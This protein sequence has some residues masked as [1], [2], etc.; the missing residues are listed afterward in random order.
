MNEDFRLRVVTVALQARSD[1]PRQRKRLNDAINECVRLSGFRSPARAAEPLLAP[2]VARRCLV[3]PE[4]VTAILDIWFAKES[5]LRAQVIEFLIKSDMKPVNTSELSPLAFHYWNLEEMGEA[6]DAFAAAN[7]GIDK[8][9][10]CLMICCVLDAVPLPI[11]IVQMIEQRMLEDAPEADGDNSSEEMTADL[12]SEPLPEPLQKFLRNLEPLMADVAGCDMIVEFARQLNALIERKALELDRMTRV[13]ELQ[14]MLDALVANESMVTYF[15]LT[16]MADWHSE[17]CKAYKLDQLRDLLEDL[18]RRF[19]AFQELQR[20]E[21]PET[22]HEKRAQRDEEDAHEKGILDAVAALRELLV[23]DDVPPTPGQELSLPEPASTPEEAGDNLAEDTER[24]SEAVAET[25]LEKDWG[26]SEIN[27]AAAESETPD[28]SGVNKQVSEE[29][30]GPRPDADEEASDASLKAPGVNYEPVAAPSDSSP[31]AQDVPGDALCFGSQNA[32]HTVA[33]SGPEA[34]DAALGVQGEVGAGLPELAKGSGA[35]A[36]PL[37]TDQSSGGAA[38]RDETPSAS[39]QTLDPIWKAIGRRDIAL[40]YWLA[41]ADEQVGSEAPLSSS[42]LG[43][44]FGAARV[45]PGSG[46]FIADLRSLSQW[47][48]AEDCVAKKVLAAAAVVRIWPVAPDVVPEWPTLAVPQLGTANDLLELV[49]RF[50]E[51]GITP[52]PDELS[53]GFQA[54]DLAREAAKIA[55][56]AEAWVSTARFRRPGLKRAHDVW[57]ALVS[58]QDGRL[59]SLVTLVRSDH[60]ESLELVDDLVKEW[61]QPGYADGVIDDLTAAIARRKDRR[62]VG[63]NRQKL[64]RDVREAVELADTWRG[65]ARQR[66]EQSIPNN[67]RRENLSKF[68]TS[69]REL[70]PQALDDI[71]ELGGSPGLGDETRAALETLREGVLALRRWV[72]TE[73]MATPEASVPAGLD[74]LVRVCR[75]LP[76]ALSRRLLYYPD[77]RLGDDAQPDPS[78]AAGLKTVLVNLSLPN[79]SLDDALKGWVANQDYRF[80]EPLLRA[81]GENASASQLADLCAH[82]LTDSRDALTRATQ[83][84]TSAIEQ[85]TI[86]GVLAD[87]RAEMLADVASIDPTTTLNCWQGH[88]LLGGLKAKLAALRA[89]RLDELREIWQDLQVDCEVLVGPVPSALQLRQ[90]MESAL[91]RGDTRVAEEL[92]DRARLAMEQS[93]PLDE[94]LWAQPTSRDS[95]REYLSAIADLDQILKRTGGL[96]LVWRAAKSGKTMA[97]IQFGGLPGPRRDEIDKGLVA[98]RNLKQGTPRSTGNVDNVRAILEYLGFRPTP[99]Q[100]EASKTTRSSVWQHMTVRAAPTGNPRAVPQFGSQALGRYDVIA[101]W[102]RPGIDTLTTALRELKLANKPVIVLYLGCLSDRQRQDLVRLSRQHM[103]TI[104]L[105]DETLVVY[106]AGQTDS[107]LPAFLRCALPFSAPMPYTP[108]QAGDVPQE[109]FYGREEMARQL[110]EFTGPCLLYGGRQLGK[111]ALLRHVERQFSMPERGQHAWVQDLRVA[112]GGLS[113]GDPEEL[114]VAL[115]DG[116]KAHGLIGAR[117]A[118]RK[119]EEI[120]RYIREALKDMTS[121][122]LVLMDESDGFLEADARQGFTT[123]IALRELILTTERRLKVVFAGLHNVRRFYGMP[124]QPLAHFGL[125]LCVGP[126]EPSAAEALVVEP[127]AAIGYRFKDAASVL[128][129]LSYTN[130]HPGLIQLFGQELLKELYRR[131]TLSYPP[132]LIEDQVVEA[133]YRRPDVRERIRERLDWTLALDTRYQVIAWSLIEDQ[134][135]AHDSYRQAYSPGEILEF[136]RYWWPAGFG[137]LSLEQLAS[138]LDEMRGLGVLASVRGGRFRLRSPN[139]V[140][141]LGTEANIVD[142]LLELGHREPEPLPVDD[143]LHMALGGSPKRY[144]PLSFAQQKVLNAPSSGV[145]LVYSSEAQGHSDTI[146]ALR[147]LVPTEQDITAEAI[148][149]VPLSVKDAASFATWLRG[150]LRLRL[151][152]QLV[153]FRVTGRTAR[154]VMSMVEEALARTRERSS[155]RWLRAIFIFD[156]LSTWEWVQLGHE[157]I[158]LAEQQALLAAHPEAWSRAGLQK[159]FEELDLLATK[160]TIDGVLKATGGW[161]CLLD[162][163]ARRCDEGVDLRPAAIVLEQDLGQPFNELVQRFSSQLGLDVDSRLPSIVYNLALW[164]PDAVRVDKLLPMSSDTGQVGDSASHW[165]VADYLVRMGCA[166]FT[167]EGVLLDPLLAKVFAPTNE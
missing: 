95:L 126:L 61:Q 2:E 120:R 30:S 133:I 109:M 26:V 16:E 10:A 86:D 154:Q 6:S 43:M 116:F 125:P 108:F 15:G 75:E 105:T 23:Q 97:T 36:L 99:Q 141:L 81:L 114:W 106:L 13:Q 136:G 163:L 118:T 96:E 56:E 84:A 39:A 11:G 47:V 142:R 100:P 12:V 122:V 45:A 130:Y 67:W 19:S 140:R 64:L 25:P 49:C 147:A 132:Y 127:L 73:P 134:L 123:V 69:L 129:I 88:L 41:W 57:Q 113:G 21:V 80:V 110:L 46:R 85:A 91:A 90:A 158:V 70:L 92:Q 37:D 24:T 104:A 151:A 63:S 1:S 76:E 107:R 48:P 65:V 152:Q 103:L 145:A 149:E 18:T 66:L 157:R 83:E 78:A 161:P 160:Q 93:H 167:P 34:S 42:L 62:I 53:G 51:M 121:S 58:E 77:L 4:L 148:A 33:P 31:Q 124:N 5:S 9:D 60:L 44:L 128:R 98:W 137:Q 139:L 164:H 165:R 82:S 35:D 115:R 28:L 38:S 111:S 7:P 68:V 162:E 112:L 101:V 40:A 59:W 153:L 3:S 32:N 143:D 20:R 71:R 94:E 79:I 144:S 74:E 138:I 135:E 55:E 22:V 166:T 54:G 17:R 131:N 155:G 87:D 29:Q 89:S 72:I 8:D 102:E 159:R 117:V 52:R 14:A 146:E 156:S 50:T 119:P 27:V 150:R